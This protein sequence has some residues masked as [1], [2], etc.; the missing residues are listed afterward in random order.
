VNDTNIDIYKTSNQS[1][2]NLKYFGGF[3]DVSANRIF[4]T[5]TL[6]TFL[7]ISLLH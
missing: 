2:S 7:H 3:R 4:S 1:F 6:M 5:T